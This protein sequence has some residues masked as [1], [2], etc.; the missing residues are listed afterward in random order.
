MKFVVSKSAPEKSKA[1]IIAIGCYERPRDDGDDGPPLPALIKHADGGIALDRAM[2]GALARQIAAEKFTGERGSSRML[3]TA[4]RIP[5]RFVLLI[6]MG[7]R[8]KF[9]L[10]VLREAG[11]EMAK[12]ARKVRASSVALVL[13]RGPVGPAGDAAAGCDD[14]APSRAQ[15]IAVGTILGSYR[16]D[17]YKTNGKKEPPLHT[18]TTFLYQGDAVPVR[19]AVEMGRIAAEAQCD[20]RDLV[21]TPA[22]DA[23]PSDLAKRAKE[24]AASSGM[25]CTV[26]GLEAMR[27]ERMNGLLLIARGSAEPPAFIVLN[28]RPKEKPRAHI[29]LVGK[30]ITFDSGGISLKPPRSM[31]VMKSDMA[32]AAAVLSA[33]DVIAKFA[34]PVEVTAY[35]P[36]A[37]N[38]P[39]GKAIKPGDIY[40]A[41]NGKTIEII[42][43]DAEGR[44]LLAD[45][46]SYAAD[47]KPDAIIDLATLTGGALYALGELYTPVMGNDQ[48]LIDRI[49][50]AAETTGEPVWQLPIVEA[51]KKGYTSGIAD[52]NNVGKGKAQTILGAIFLREFV[53]GVPWVHMDIAAS[54]WTDEDIPLSPR[55]GTGAMVRT[56]VA[57]V[58]SFK[59]SVPD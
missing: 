51:Y 43:T 42:S 57:F 29:A 25:R 3:F 2:G 37:E 8:E 40:A 55:G 32:G 15:A 27:K 39:D 36:A 12:A 4:G 20:C 11:S 18:L 47:S 31:E 35:I 14:S 22:L 45:A 33:M 44:L 38:L 53:N 28:Y 23:T 9:D 41:R 56:L 7:P 19:A 34:P 13:E 52:L 59:K 58:G 24:L 30:G 1:E 16:F 26:F 17:R 5:A 50:R 49:R 46:L 21:N 54:S 6:G 48:K 10:E